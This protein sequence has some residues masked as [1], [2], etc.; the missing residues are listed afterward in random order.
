M[1][2]LM[3]IINGMFNKY[4]SLY[5]VLCFT[6]NMSLN[7]QQ[8][9][10]K[11]SSRVFDNNIQTVEFKKQYQD[12]YEAEQLFELQPKQAISLVENVLVFIIDNKV[13]LVKE[14]KPNKSINKLKGSA[15]ELLGDFNLRNKFY[16][17][18]LENYLNAESAYKKSNK[19]YK[20]IKLLKNIAKIQKLN[21]EYQQ[22]LDYYLELESVLEFKGDYINTIATKNSIGELYYILKQLKLAEKYHSDAL[23]LALKNNY[24]EGIEMSNLLI[25]V[26]SAKISEDNSISEFDKKVNQ[27]SNS[28]GVN[29]LEDREYNLDKIKE[30]FHQ[31]KQPEY[32]DSISNTRL[33]DIVKSTFTTNVNAKSDVNRAILSLKEQI[34][35]ASNKKAFP[36]LASALFDLHNLYEKCGKHDLALE[37]LKSY[38]AIQ[39]SLKINLKDNPIIDHSEID[40]E[41]NLVQQKLLFLEKNKDLDLRTIEVLKQQQKVDQEAIRNGKERTL[42]LIGGL[43]LLGLIIVLVIRLNQ[44]RKRANELLRLKGLQAQMNPHFIFNTLNSVNNFISK[45]DERSANRYISDFS[46]L[47]RQVLELAQED[48]ISLEQEIEMLSLYLKLEHL[49]FKDKFEY[50]IE[51]E[52]FIDTSDI[53]IPPMLVQP[54]IENA[55]WHGLRYK[56]SNGKLFVNVSNHPT[57]IMI[58]I[59]DNGIGRLKSAELKT[60]NQKNHQSTALRNIESRLAYIKKLFKQK[61]EVEIID[62]AIGEGTKVYIKLF[63]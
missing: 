3:N 51:V 41:L 17:Q 19:G 32:K 27:I 60:K 12:L 24:Q 53:L 1:S 40:E 57:Y 29:N 7:A 10:S 31:K 6:F 49:R 9:N 2:K 26:L 14:G 52:E 5:I 61:L 28:F 62:K 50:R 8:L 37:T 16:N 54:F 15:L 47:M 34:F 43:V 44:S 38:Y 21:H 23:T 59:D 42:F 35:K 33:S 48:L 22:S 46:K 20:S 39:D 18:A 55:I 56:E 58:S 25:D 4:V 13:S 11:G 36:E 63:K 30:G 45:N